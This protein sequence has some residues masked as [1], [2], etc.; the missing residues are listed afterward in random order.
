MSQ[1]G[2]PEDAP[3][4]VVLE[5]YEIPV[6]STTFR[7][8]V[9]DAESVVEVQQGARSPRTAVRPALRQLGLLDDLSAPHERL[10]RDRRGR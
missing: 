9:S 2:L 3:I 4:E 1:N 10:V 6:D 7:K 8:V 5:Y